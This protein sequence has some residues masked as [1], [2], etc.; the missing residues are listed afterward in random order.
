MIS[1]IEQGDGHSFHLHVLE[2]IGITTSKISAPVVSVK[3]LQIWKNRQDFADSV[4]S[5]S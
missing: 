2:D 5:T 4:L 1:S 3:R